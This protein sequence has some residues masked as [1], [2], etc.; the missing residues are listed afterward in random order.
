LQENR[1]ARP[2][3]S[4]AAAALALALHPGT[5]RAEPAAAEQPSFARNVAP[6]LERWCVSCHGARE[7]QGSLRLD[8]Y[9]AVFAGGDSGPPVIAGEPGASLLVAKIERR[10]RPAM[11][12]RKRLP[13]PAVAALRAWIAAGAAP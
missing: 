8:S 9:E 10:D 2:A 4:V 7:Q 12:P 6:L 3:F 13:K 11:P 1:R 5:T